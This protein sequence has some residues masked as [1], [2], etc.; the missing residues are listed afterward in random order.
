MDLNLILK[1]NIADL[2]KKS[3]KYYDQQNIDNEKYINNKQISFDKDAFEIKIIDNKKVIL[4]KKYQIL[5]I[6]DQQTKIWIWAWLLPNLSKDE[7]TL[8]RQLLDYG[9]KL[10]PGT[11]NILHSYIKSQ[12]VNA[13]FLI[14][15]NIELDINLA[16]AAYL[17]KNNYSFI[18]PYI[19][20]FNKEKTK[21]QTIYYLI[22]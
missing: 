16:I 1:N 21:Y 8:S 2:I 19:L 10:D 7:T 12:L 22:I 6:F 5:G 9:L 15:D 14:E 17:L 4:K 3:L 20:Y 11:N 13:R 18:Y